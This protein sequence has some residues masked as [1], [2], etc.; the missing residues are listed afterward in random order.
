MRQG[1][2]A[3]LLGPGGPRG[4]CI[5]MVYVAL[6]NDKQAVLTAILTQCKPDGKQLAVDLNSSPKL[7]NGE[8]YGRVYSQIN[9]ESQLDEV[10]SPNGTLV[11]NDRGI[12]TADSISAQ[13]KADP[14][15]RIITSSGAKPN[16]KTTRVIPVSRI[17]AAFIPIVI[18]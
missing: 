11:R 14:S 6:E 10:V 1:D 7:D 4:S 18:S 9:A 12:K 13:H 2:S 3:D 17:E 8:V 16:P 5:D 15:P